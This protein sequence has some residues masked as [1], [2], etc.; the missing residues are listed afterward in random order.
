MKVW[1]IKRRSDGWC[2]TR[3]GSFHKTHK[4]LYPQR[5]HCINALYLEADSKLMKSNRKEYRTLVEKK[6]DMNRD[7]NKRFA[8]MEAEVDIQNAQEVDMGE[9]W[10]IN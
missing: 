7:L 8:I 2:R 3:A 6:R 10:C 5:G 1:Y 9:Y 4:I